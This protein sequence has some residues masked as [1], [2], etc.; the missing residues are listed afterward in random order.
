MGTPNAA[1]IDQIA[2]DQL[3]DAIETRRIQRD[4]M[5]TTTHLSRQAYTLYAGR[6]QKDAVE[7]DLEQSIASQPFDKT[8]V[9]GQL[10]FERNVANGL[11]TN[12]A[13]ASGILNLLAKTYSAKV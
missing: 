7:M 12:E 2:G 10:A 6:A 11:M 13:Y 8:A 1:L 4:E 3:T 9:T 5:L